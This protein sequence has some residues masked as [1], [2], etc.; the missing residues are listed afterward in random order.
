ML[1]QRLRWLLFAL[2]VSWTKLQF[3]EALPAHD[4][5]SRVFANTFSP[6]VATSTMIRQDYNKRTHPPNGKN[7]TQSSH[8]LV[9]SP[10]GLL[11][12]DKF[13]FYTYD[14]KG[15]MITRQMTVEEIQG[16]IAAGGA[17]HVAMD[18]QEPQKADDVLTGGKKV[19]DVVQKVQNVLKSALDK[20]P[21]LTGTIPKIPEHANVEWSNILPSILSGETDAISPGGESHKVTTE[22]IETSSPV[23]S[24]LNIGT[25]A[26]PKDPVKK[27]DVQTNAYAGFTNNM[28]HGEKPQHGHQQTSISEKPMIPVPV[29]T[30]TEQKLSTL[31]PAFTESPVFQMVSVIPVAEKVSQTD[32]FAAD[33][34][35]YAT[36]QLPA[37][38]EELG[39]TEYVEITLSEVPEDTT[40][41][42][43]SS[44]NTHPA[45][46]VTKQTA[47]DA[48]QEV[49]VP[50]IHYSTTTPGTADSST[51]VDTKKIVTHDQFGEATS[52]TDKI[53]PLN[54][55][56]ILLQSKNNTK[57]SKD[58]S[59]V[60]GVTK[61]P[62]SVTHNDDKIIPQTNIP[63]S[64]A[65]APLKGAEEASNATA[66]YSPS[67]LASASGIEISTAPI[68]PY[69]S[70]RLGEGSTTIT[71]EALSSIT[72]AYTESHLDPRPTKI[73]SLAPIEPLRPQLIDSLSS[74]M[75]QVAE[76]KPSVIS[77]SSNEAPGMS[78]VNYDQRRNDS[79]K[80]TI[81]DQH[82]A[83][84]GANAENKPTV[85]PQTYATTKA[86]LPDL[87]TWLVDY[88][89]T[90]RPLNALAAD[91]E[92]IASE[93]TSGLTT[94]GAAITP[95][96]LSI[97]STTISESTISPLWTQS[98]KTHDASLEDQTAA[99]ATL[100]IATATDAA[101]DETTLAEILPTASTALD[102]TTKAQS[103]IASNES[104][105]KPTAINF[106]N[107]LANLNLSNPVSAIDQV[108]NLASLLSSVP[109]IE[110]IDL[111]SDTSNF[112]AS[113]LASGLIAGFATKS[114]VKETDE[115]Q[116]AKDTSSATI[117]DVTK[118]AESI[119]NVTQMYEETTGLNDDYR[120]NVTQ[121]PFFKHPARNDTLE[122][123][124]QTKETDKT[125]K[126]IKL[127]NEKLEDSA[128]ASSSLSPNK[129]AISDELKSSAQS[130][131][132]TRIVTVRP[133]QLSTMKIQSPNVN[134]TL[135]D[136]NN[137][138]QKK[139]ENKEKLKTTEAPN[140][141]IDVSPDEFIYKIDSSKNDIKNATHV[142]NN[143]RIET[144]DKKESLTNA[145]ETKETAEIHS[146]KHISNITTNAAASSTT[147]VTDGSST[148]SVLA[149]NHVTEPTTV[150]KIKDTNVA[151]L[152]TPYAAT[153]NRI[154]VQNNKNNYDSPSSTPSIQTD[155]STDSPIAAQKLSGDSKKEELSRPS[156][157]NGTDSLSS[158]NNT[159]LNQNKDVSS[160]TELSTKNA[161]MQANLNDTESKPAALKHS[162]NPYKSSTPNPVHQTSKHPTI[163][164]KPAEK[165]NVS[166]TDAP[167][168]AE[169]KWTL[170]SQQAT[171]TMTKLPKPPRPLKPPRKPV[172][173]QT[174]GSDDSA[175]LRS[176]STE[177]TH[178]QDQQDLSLQSVLPLDAS[179]S[180]S[181][182][183]VT[184]RHTSSDI[185]NFA[186]LCNELAFNFWMATNKGLSTA[187]SLALSPFGMTSLLA[188]IFLGARGPTSD[189]MNEILGL[190]D[191]AT[192]N[193]HLVFQNITDT[194]S[195]ARGQGI[196]NAAF[197]RELFADKMKV[198]KL[199]PF[200]KEQAQQFYEGL[201]TEVNFA[202]ISDLVR[203]RT[204]LLIRKQTGGRIKDFVKTNTVPLR[205]PLAAL[206][207]NVF[208]TDCNSTLTSSV[209]RDGE[210]YF[211]VSPAV[212]QRKLVP[213]PATTWR[214][215]VLAGYEPSIDATAVA[216]GA[217]EKLVS[218]I[219]L[220]P[221][222]QGHTAPGDT[223]DRLEQRLVR[224]AFRDG[225]WNK[226]LKVLIPRN[227]L[228]LQVPKFSHRSVINATAAL[229]RMGL[230]EL[231]SGN[232]DF[233]GING[234]GHRLHLADVLQMNLFSTCGDEN[235]LSGRHHVE[236]YPASPLRRNIKRQPMEDT[237]NFGKS[238]EED[239]PRQH[240][241]VSSQEDHAS[242][243]HGDESRMD[244]FYRERRQ[245]SGSSEKPKLK[246][247]RPFLYF[248]RHNPSGII[249]HMGRFNPRL[250]V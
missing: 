229:K 119:E 87:T 209:G 165:L 12:P 158:A 37:Q 56:Y 6:S 246:L 191:V 36:T 211:A 22:R 47:N 106:D 222:Q 127:S 227:G 99:P 52:M 206:S 134:E 157:A 179:Q 126:P 110:P 112:V 217:S 135:F 183:D 247:D 4:E 43:L 166:K 219:F 108:L 109:A 223:L 177:A 42:Q 197:V 31:Q 239:A 156:L 199:M 93:G 129:I 159:L 9:A 138:N 117:S 207:A 153:S 2:I 48:D 95:A 147:L 141:R 186:R 140:I 34:A 148:K 92:P 86:P 205:S 220:L 202:T 90:Y 189:Q 249:L 53:P 176:P 116:V 232:A 3:N 76:V 30:L 82:D 105:N 97:E 233:K 104:L 152:T 144:L 180:A 58:P 173:Q 131:I 103:T 118:L 59:F 203:R 71:K 25:S 184:I 66:L 38:T 192:F 101:N 11:R 225:A 208:Q 146:H 85:S 231:F 19:M 172:G 39:Q 96:G 32:S 21:T 182:L 64:H 241:G 243:F 69:T 89:V 214:S 91:T 137:D 81:A 24:A 16:L 73:Q 190:D 213:V 200:Y 139:T 133:E 114:P 41:S 215:G 188:M 83:S 28:Q 60:P 120:K 130:T 235:I 62:Q 150:H 88:T 54:V 142:E 161:S 168:S 68:P 40:F 248:V 27:P 50:A 45:D 61:E 242:L 13:Q 102:A 29:I 250:L 121:Q 1:L 185:V 170:I 194:V 174:S 65:S 17:D 221:G 245:L 181:G 169:D 78:H 236:T 94:G 74:V 196:A 23:E 244:Q 160:I 10:A 55:S 14:E 216:L 111:P 80:V 67:T 149:Q 15:D 113:D 77:L 162:E 145:S 79:D 107:A 151:T 212:R 210:L 72:P 224:S 70:H 237:D 218:T 143:Q 123:I 98:E 115:D 238:A 63:L 49:G 228:E 122:L 198:R 204:N 20:P 7:D 35:S 193:P 195:L 226:L 230:D 154:A 124:S 187:R 201:V 57:P 171:P 234:V 155:A 18:K 100:E 178:Q 240:S 163:E 125:S 5:R 46:D 84:H 136:K 8:K 44:L 26:T 75:N 164:H 51:T 33:V 167:V 128:E 175:N 132:T